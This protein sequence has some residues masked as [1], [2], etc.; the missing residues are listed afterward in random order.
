MNRCITCNKPVNA[1]KAYI[2]LSYKAE[3]YL[4]CCPLC[5]STFEKDP[6][7]YIQEKGKKHRRPAH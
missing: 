5:Q 2:S 6:E 7:K 4:V 1:N 3:K